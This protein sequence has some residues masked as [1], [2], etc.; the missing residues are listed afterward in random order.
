VVFLVSEECSVTG[1]VLSAANGVFAVRR[2]ERSEGIDFGSQP[3]EPETIAEHRA[4]I[5]GLN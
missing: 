5:A 2:W 4:E 3:V 1:V